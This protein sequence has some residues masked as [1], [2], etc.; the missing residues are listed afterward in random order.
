M[1]T[2]C[3]SVFC[4]GHAGIPDGN[5][6]GEIVTP[7]MNGAM[8]CSPDCAAYVEEMVTECAPRFETMTDD[9]TGMTYNQQLEPFLAA[10]QGMPPPPPAA[11]GGHRRAQDVEGVED[12]IV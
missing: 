9:A 2:S 8:Y 3:V 12:I 6:D 5:P 11:G 4:V 7:M 1:V 10:C